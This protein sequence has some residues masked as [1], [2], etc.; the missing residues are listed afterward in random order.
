MSLKFLTQYDALELSDKPT[1][2]SSQTFEYIT[3]ALNECNSR[4]RTE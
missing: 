4:S 2:R 1:H 3:R